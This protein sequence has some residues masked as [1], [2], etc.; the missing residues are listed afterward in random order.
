LQDI[1]VAE[2]ARQ[3]ERLVAYTTQARFAVAQ[4]HDRAKVAK[5]ATATQGAADVT[6]R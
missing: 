5:V 6:P 1:A 2:L 3:K 4:L